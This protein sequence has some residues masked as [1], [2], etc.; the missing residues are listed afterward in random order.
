MSAALAGYL[1]ITQLAQHLDLTLPDDIAG[2]DLYGADLS[3]ANLSRADL[4]GARHN[5]RTTWPAGFAP[6]EQA[7]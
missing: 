3:G 6:T 1:A 5:S 7:P 2:A 4:Y